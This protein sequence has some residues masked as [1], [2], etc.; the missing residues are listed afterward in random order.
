MLLKCLFLLVLLSLFS[1][2][3]NFPK[4]ILWDL[5]HW[6]KLGIPAGYLV[7]IADSMA[8]RECKSGASPG[9]SCADSK[10][11]RMPWPLPAIQGPSHVYTAK[12]WL[13]SCRLPDLLFVWLFLIPSPSVV[14]LSHGISWWTSPTI[15]SR[16]KR[17]PGEESWWPQCL[18]PFP[19]P[20]KSP[21]TAP[22]TTVR[23][24]LRCLWGGVHPPQVPYLYIPDLS[25]L[26][27]CLSWSFGFLQ[28]FQRAWDQ[29]RHALTPQQNTSLAW[30][31]LRQLTPTVCNNFVP[32]PNCLLT[33]CPFSSSFLNRLNSRSPRTKPPQTSLETSFKCGRWPFTLLF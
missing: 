7:L 28:A 6:K 22:V 1:C 18:Y 24:H 23:W 32:S 26:L 30:K 8:H 12:L 29:C 5:L 17:K 27:C 33:I 3:Y 31:E 9:S 21:S 14:P 4:H 11:Y 15:P 2:L 16:R 19:F 10:P 25:S 20:L 13:L